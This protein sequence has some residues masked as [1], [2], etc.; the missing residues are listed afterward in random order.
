MPVIRPTTSVISA[1]SQVVVA[2]TVAATSCC[3]SAETVYMQVQIAYVAML[4]SMNQVASFREL[5]NVR[6]Y[7]RLYKFSA[8]Y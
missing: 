2:A 3:F 1:A 7:H 8:Y 6:A 5:W 4:Q